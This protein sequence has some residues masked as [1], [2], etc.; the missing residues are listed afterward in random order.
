[1]KS[2]I[3]V[4]SILFLFAVGSVELIPTFAST[5]TT[6]FKVINVSWGTPNNPTGA[7]PGD[8]NLPLTVTLQYVFPNSATNIQGLLELSNGFSTYNGSGSAF[9]SVTGITS[10]G[11]MVQMT[12]QVYLASNLA[13]GAYTLPLNLSWTASG[14]SYTLNQSSSIT[15]YVEG[16]PQ[17]YFSASSQSLAP[18]QVNLVPLIIQNTGSGSA[19]TISI[20]ATSQVAGI[21]NSVPQVQYIGAGAQ[22]TYTL[23]IYVPLTAA[24]AVVP[25]SLTATYKDP[26]GNSGTV[27]QS[28]FLYASAAGVAKLQFSSNQQTLVPGTSN[29]VTITL[30]N[31]GAQSLSQVVTSITS[32]SPSVTILGTF[33]YLASLNANASVNSVIGIYVAPSASSSPFSITLTS[34]YIV[35]QN[36]MSGSTSQSLGFY[37]TNSPLT[38]ISLNVVSVNTNLTAGQNS[39]VSFIVKNAGN[40]PVYSPSFSLT[41]LT[42]LVIAANS[43]YS[44]PGTIIAPGGSVLYEA[45]LTS[46]PSSTPG[47]YSG[48]LAV[49]ISDK[50]GNQRTQT[51][52]VGFRLAGQI[53]LVITGEQI[54]QTNQTLVVSGTIL[55]KGTTPA[56]YAQVG[57]QANSEAGQQSYLGEIDVNTPLPFSIVV[58]AKLPNSGTEPTNVTVSISF[59]DNF[60]SN[61]QIVLTSHTTLL[62]PQSGTE[63]IT[64]QRQTPFRA[65]DLIFSVVIIVLVL[66]LAVV[67]LRRRG[68]RGKETKVI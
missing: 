40:S 12:F 38:N 28:L 11:M 27:S 20:T 65:L 34:S 1:M 18:G 22:S 33:P 58:P 59:Q 64:T 24:G 66:V 67:L 46:S 51:F 41:T 63:T 32:G 14:Y 53:D 31:T 68:S 16:R 4:F 26:Y 3:L 21:L 61:R 57:G 47:I 56:Y 42:P 36:G 55:N 44:L 15:V 52:S 30:T 25:V 10:T 54:V 7:A 48:S 49:T 60:G 35:N 19:S 43:T 5:S 29:N 23:Q 13:L 50:Q 8:S 39:V 2:K 37:T 6:G 17:I 62:P 45:T 9:S